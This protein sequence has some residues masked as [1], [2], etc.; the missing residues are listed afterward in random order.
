M[1]NL[2]GCGTAL[3]TPFEKNLEVDFVAFRKLVRRQIAGGIHFLVPLGTTGET[4]CLDDREKI[5]LLEI[6]VEETGK[7]IPVIA[8]AGSNSTKQVI[9]NIAALGKTGIDAFLVVTPYYNKPTQDGLYNHFKTV[10]ESTD[11]PIIMYNVPGRTSVNMSAETCLKLAEIKNII[12]TKEASGNYA[13]I[14]EIIRNAPKDFIVLSGN[15]DET[16]SLVSTGA[17]GVIS[18]AS[19]IAPQLMSEFLNKL[20]KG[21]IDGARE[22]HH[23]LSP[24]FKNCF[25]ESNPIPVKAGMHKM[26][27]LENVLRPPLYTSTEKTL[28]IMEAALKELNLL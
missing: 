15:D 10:A 2:N 12:A 17:K 22:L 19:N 4:P 24:L 14:S 3:V 20:L 26:G 23:R 16:L 18:V 25:V 13:Q 6:T 7:R 27:L 5:H 21:D 1:I 8:G 9:S 28:G 11:K